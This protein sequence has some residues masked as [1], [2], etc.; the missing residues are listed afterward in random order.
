MEIHVE[1][2]PISPQMDT[3]DPHSWKEIPLPNHVTFRVH[4]VCRGVLE[5]CLSTS[6]QWNKKSGDLLHIG[7]Q[8][9]TQLYGDYKNATARIP[10][11]DN[12]DAFPCSKYPM[13]RCFFGSPNPLQNQPLPEGRLGAYGM[14]HGIGI[15]GVFFVAIWLFPK[16]G[17]FPLNHPFVHRVPSMIFTIHFWGTHYFWSS[18]HPLRI[19]GKWYIYLHEWLIFMVFM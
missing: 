7:D 3:K 13:R 11:L 17:G 2:L 1:T 12:Q 16:I 18:T 15:W 10:F 6:E 14:T 9:T 5:V 19:H 4:V 8:T